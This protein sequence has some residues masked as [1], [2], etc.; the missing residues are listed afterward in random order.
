MRTF[1]QRSVTFL[2][3]DD[4]ALVCGRCGAEVTP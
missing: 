3:L 2:D 1:G 4:G